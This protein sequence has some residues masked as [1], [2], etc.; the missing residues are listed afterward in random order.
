V[1]VSGP[2]QAARYLA[3]AR[4]YAAQATLVYDA[5]GPDE[6]GRDP[7]TVLA[8]GGLA[9]GPAQELRRAET[10]SAACSDVVLAR[11]VEDRDR[12]L[13]DVP[14]A[15][16]EVIADAA[17]RLASVLTGVRAS[18]VGAAAGGSTA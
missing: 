16:V 18:P 13:R 11:T 10:V 5:Y 1:L 8:D 17:D 3:P 12:L 7:G 2:E 15:R 4:A 6:P 14:G 9:V